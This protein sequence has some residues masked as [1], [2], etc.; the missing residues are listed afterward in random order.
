M[1]HICIRPL[2]PGDRTAVVDA[3]ARLSAE[4]RQQRFLAHKPALSERELTELTEVNH[5]TRE[6]LAAVEGSEIVGMARYAM[7]PEADRVA[8][9]ALE[10][11]DDRQGRGIGRRLT[12]RIIERARA[13][14][15]GR[16]TASVLSENRAAL[17]L[18][19]RFGFK[20][21]DRDSGVTTLE[22]E[23]DRDTAARE[24]RCADIGAAPGRC[25]RLRRR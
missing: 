1:G 13:A 7:W 24:A 5:R 3:F 12:A 25:R 4:S 17:A 20:V 14:S 15:I 16:L 19:R 8:D 2:E 11:V 22:L 10:V 6:A 23:L 21:A 18:L 9:L